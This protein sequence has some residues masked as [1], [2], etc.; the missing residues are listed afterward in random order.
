MPT[1]TRQQAV[2]LAALDWLFDE[3]DEHRRSGRT[4]VLAVAYLRRAARTG[5]WVDPEDHHDGGSRDSDLYLLR[6]I[7]ELASQVGIRL[8]VD[9]RRRFRVERLS[10]QAERLLFEGFVEGDVPAVA[11]SERAQQEWLVQG[12]IDIRGVRPRGAPVPPA[13]PPPAP[14]SEKPPPPNLWERLNGDDVV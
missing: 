7:Q 3:S 9:G 11:A 4:F 6:V 5:R 13:S 14:E 12:L 8:D 2:A 1:I 10:P